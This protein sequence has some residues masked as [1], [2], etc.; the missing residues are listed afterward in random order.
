VFGLPQVVL[1]LLVYIF[2]SYVGW[3]VGNGEWGMGSREVGIGKINIV[4]WAFSCPALVYFSIGNAIN[5][6][7]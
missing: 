6:S 2:I 4:G 7:N 1:L 5:I 3:G